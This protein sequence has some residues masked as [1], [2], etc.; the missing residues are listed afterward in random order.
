LLD[1]CVYDLWGQ[2]QSHGRTG[3]RQNKSMADYY[4]LLNK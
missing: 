1:T 4:C 2:N 3:Q